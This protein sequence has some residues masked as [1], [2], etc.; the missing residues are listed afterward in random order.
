MRISIQLNEICQKIPNFVNSTNKPMNKKTYLQIASFLSKCSFKSKTEWERIIAIVKAEV[1]QAP[2]FSY[3]IDPVNGITVHDF[4]YWEDNSFGAGDICRVDDNIVICG[5][6]GL[7][8]ATIVGKLSDDKILILDET[9]AQNALKSANR[10]EQYDFMCV[11][12]KDRLQFSLKEMRLIEKYVPQPGERVIFTSP[13]FSGLGVVK[14]IHF[15]TD[16][17]DYFCYFINET[18]KVGFSMNEV[19]ITGLSDVVFEPM[20]NG[21]RR[22][23]KG[24]GIY[25]QRKLNRELGRYG[26]VWNEKLHRIEPVNGQVA[27]GEKYWFLN[28]R[29]VLMEDVEKGRA[30]SR[31]R[32]NAG[33]Y[34]CSHA[35]GLEYQ[36]LFAE[37]LRNRLADPNCNNPEGRVEE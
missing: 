27:I 14:T 20:N 11:M 8:C 3:T 37:I 33:N 28:D 10:D 24:N 25:L 26:K 13:G 34:F 22:E 6:C 16:T 1:G 4:L 18:K 23:T 2:N 19:G 32:W 36:G 29:M 30:L 9:V 35:S 12:L 17:V 31:A 21:L 5:I 7:E 15:D